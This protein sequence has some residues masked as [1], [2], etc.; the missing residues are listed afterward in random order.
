[1]RAIK[2][3]ILHCSANSVT[4]KMRAAD[5]KKYHVQVNKWSDI[6]YHYVIP[7]DGVVE[8]GRPVE[9]VGAHCSG[10]NSDSIGIC[11]VGGLASDGKTPQDTR[12]KAQK[13]ALRALVRTLLYKY[14]LTPAQVHCHNE[15][16]SKACPS[17]KIEDFR[18]E[19]L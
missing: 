19:L 17:F 11:Y 2:Q 1:M 6:G 12:T 8:Q 9:Q 15:Y 18:K 4:C 5:I 10:Q 3:I 16:S 7:T 13:E 14:K